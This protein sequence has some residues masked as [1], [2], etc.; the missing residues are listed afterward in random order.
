MATTSTTHSGNDQR[1][2]EAQPIMRQRS[3]ETQPFGTLARYPLSLGDDARAASVEALNQVLCDT[4]VLRDMYKKHH[5]Q[6]SGPT[7]YAIHLLFDKHAS[8][9]AELID[10]LAE[11]VQTLGGVAIAMAHDVAEMTRV[12]RVPRGREELPVQL[13]RLLE[14][15]E[16]VLKETRAAA[17]RAAEMGDDGTNDIFVSEVIRTNELQVWFVAEHLVDTP[18][19]RAK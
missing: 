8:E 19:V 14:A 18:L 6:A 11:R 1:L 7:F 13:S 12:E 9:Q 16:V 10:L 3:R 15:H 17:K 5:W 4:I 2:R